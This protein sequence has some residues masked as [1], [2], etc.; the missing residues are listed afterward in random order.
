MMNKISSG[1][2]LALVSRIGCPRFFISA[3]IPTPFA[4]RHSAGWR[5]GCRAT[6]LQPYT[7]RNTLHLNA[8]AVRCD[9][10]GA[11]YWWAG[12]ASG[13]TLG[14][15]SAITPRPASRPNRPSVCYLTGLDARSA[16]QKDSTGPLITLTSEPP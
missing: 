4:V 10:H 9:A 16:L 7:S 15:C 12:E 2:Q 3:Y 8:L 14:R 13:L 1:V 11:V 5:C 6:K